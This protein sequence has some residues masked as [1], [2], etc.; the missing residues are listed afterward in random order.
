M[1]STIHPITRWWYEDEAFF[2]SSYSTTSSQSAPSYVHSGAMILNHPSITVY[3]QDGEVDKWKYHQYHTKPEDIFLF[4]TLSVFNP[5]CWWVYA[6][7]IQNSNP[8]Y[9]GCRIFIYSTEYFVAELGSITRF[10]LIR[11]TTDLISKADQSNFGR[12]IPSHR[13]WF[14]QWCLWH[15]LF[16]STRVMMDALYPCSIRGWNCKHHPIEVSTQGSQSDLFNYL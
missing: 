13:R 15:N 6:A 4:S 10:N 7:L 11:A 5:P 16:D 14:K 3:F 12:I 1:L 2:C 9:S 8:A